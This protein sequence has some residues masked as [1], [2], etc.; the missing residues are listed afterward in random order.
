MMTDVQSPSR[1]AQASQAQDSSA[2]LMPISPQKTSESLGSQPTA[3][4]GTIPL[5]QQASPSAKGIEGAS[6]SGPIPQLSP[7]SAMA[8]GMRKCSLKREALDPESPTSSKRRR[9]FDDG[10]GVTQ[11]VDNSGPVGNKKSVQRVQKAIRR[12]A[13]VQKKS[14]ELTPASN[15]IDF[16]AEWIFNG[17]VQGNP[18]KDGEGTEGFGGCPNTATQGP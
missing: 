17:S 4:I 16:P 11:L 18:E 12:R 7:I 13:E 1:E 10:G 3:G 6:F 14:L 2:H 5:V 15:E 9:L 8:H